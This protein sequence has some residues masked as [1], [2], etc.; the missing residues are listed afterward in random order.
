[1]YEMMKAELI[2]LYK[3]LFSFNFVNKSKKHLNFT[4]FLRNYENNNKLR[5]PLQFIEKVA[6][7]FNL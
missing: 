7:I 4:K 2:V 3:K 5:F 6:D 1:M